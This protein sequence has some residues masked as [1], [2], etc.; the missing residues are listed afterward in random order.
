MVNFKE[1]IEIYTDKP[2]VQECG[3]KWETQDSYFWS[4]KTCVNLDT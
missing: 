1:H 3:V 4:H 2:G